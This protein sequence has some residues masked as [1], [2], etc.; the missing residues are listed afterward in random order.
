MFY[1]EARGAA[2]AGFYP[3]HGGFPIQS[4]IAEHVARRVKPSGFYPSLVSHLVFECDDSPGL[5]PNDFHRCNGVRPQDLI[6]ITSLGLTLP[7]MSIL[8]T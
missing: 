6:Q 5:K 1:P 3:A 4:H 7:C 2:P 8:C